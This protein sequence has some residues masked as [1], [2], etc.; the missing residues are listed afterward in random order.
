MSE[1]GNNMS[2]RPQAPTAD[3][4]FGFVDCNPDPFVVPEWGG[5]TVYLRDL[6]AGSSQDLNNKLKALN[7]DQI[8]EGL[9][10]TVIATVCNEKG[11]LIFTESHMEQ[12][13]TRNV[14]VLKRLQDA[15]LEKLGWDKK[16]ELKNASGETPTDVSPIASPENL[17]AAT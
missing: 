9:C 5:R 12:L 7:D 16:A 10:L 13:M 4:I 2:E 15:A 8:S 1:R 11:E 3:E 17:V 6:S 14:H